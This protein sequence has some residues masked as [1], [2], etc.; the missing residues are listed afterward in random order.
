MSQVE[1]LT[2]ISS[3]KLR[4]W[5]RRYGFLKPM[6]TETNIRFYSE[7]QLKNLLNVGILNRNGFRISKIDKMSKDEIHENVTNILSNISSSHQDE[8][9]ALV[10]HMMEFNEREFQN[11]FQRSIIRNGF[12]NTILEIIYPFLNQ[13]GI[14]WGTNKIIVAQEH[15]ISNLIRQKIISA[16]ENLPL[17]GENAPSLVLFLLD[18]EDHEMGLLLSSFIA[19][20]MGWA[21]YYFG[22]RVPSNEVKIITDKIRPDLILSLFIRNHNSSEVARISEA[23]QANK[24]IPFLVSGSTHAIDQLELSPQCH[25]IKNPQEYIDYL[26]EW[27]K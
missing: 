14:L 8:I 12:M 26:E 2:G 13:I 22:Q 24:D 16:I 25:L 6:R 5:E 7:E 19:K 9:N 15:F 20:K 1:V 4:I 10:L 17:P 18:N 23:L 3:H 27:T 11:V 21:V